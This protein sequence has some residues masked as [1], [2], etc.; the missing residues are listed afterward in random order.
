MSGHRFRTHLVVRH[1]RFGG[2]KKEAETL[3]G[4]SRIELAAGAGRYARARH[5][6]WDLYRSLRRLRVG[7]AGSTLQSQ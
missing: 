6:D 1:I 3:S 2:T 5:L 4:D 7:D